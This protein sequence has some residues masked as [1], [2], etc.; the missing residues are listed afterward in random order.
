MGDLDRRYVA[1]RHNYPHTQPGRAEQ[2]RSEVVGH[3]DAAM[4]R[5]MSRQRA[6]VECNTRPSDALHVWHVGIVIQVR[7][8]LGFFLDDGEDTRWRL[9]S[10][11]AA[12]YRRPQNP[13]FGVIDSDPLVAQRN[14]GHDRLNRLTPD[15]GLDERH[16]AFVPTVCGARIITR[17]DHRGQTGNRKT[18]R[19]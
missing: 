13:A 2:A 7:V 16:R 4:R 10:L 8:V 3:P 17:R 12:R 9:A 11:P 5:R 15:A 19:P 1:W 18:S 6:T 14:D